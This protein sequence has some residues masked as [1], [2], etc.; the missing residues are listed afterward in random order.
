MAKAGHFFS[1]NI[2]I[3][4]CPCEGGR[5]RADL[6]HN[7]LS[8][9]MTNIIRLFF[10][11]LSVSGIFVLG[12]SLY[13]YSQFSYPDFID[14]L[15][16]DKLGLT[17]FYVLPAALSISALLVLRLEAAVRKKLFIHSVT[18]IIGIYAAELYIAFKPVKPAILYQVEAAKS[19]GLPNDA[20][21]RQ[22]YVMALRKAGIDAYPYAGG[23]ELLDH[24]NWTNGRLISPIMVENQQ[25]VP[26]AGISK[27]PTV[28]CKEPGTWLTY[29]ADRYGFNNPDYVWDTNP[30]QLSI[31]GD[32]FIHGYCL[33]NEAHAMQ[34]VRRIFPNMVNLGFSGRGALQYLA[35]L[36]EYGPL[37]RPKVVIWVHYEN[38]IEDMKSEISNDVLS[39]YINHKNFRQG[40]FEHQKKVDA[41]T[42][43]YI[44]NFMKTRGTGL[45]GERG[46]KFS[47]PVPTTVDFFNVLALRYL[48]NVFKVYF[49]R[50]QND[51]N[52]F[53]RVISRALEVVKSWNGKIYFVYRPLGHR[54]YPGSSVVLR[55]YD[56]ERKN[57]LSIVERAGIPIID[58]LPIFKEDLPEPWNLFP[59]SHYAHAGHNLFADT[60]L[61]RLKIDGVTPDPVN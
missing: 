7:I 51:L 31:I 32:S 60:V 54:G 34:Q 40:M 6:I 52:L 37:I 49:K 12:R 16:F 39:N 8:R 45:L 53:K 36:I 13:K 1:H 43:K 18:I 35:T 9:P 20:R 23:G 14:L 4:Y 59:G 46:L 24:G 33:P 41:A 10:I 44:N 19:A 27:K 26:L 47:E 48:R 30:V 58:L 57:V 42:M 5:N 38:D 55:K 15:Q 28:L 2:R 17:V 56:Y 11:F 3:N 29:L 22:E 21:S 25:F 61:K 50:E